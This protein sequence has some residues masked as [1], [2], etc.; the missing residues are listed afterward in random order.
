MFHAVGRPFIRHYNAK[1][2]LANPWG[3]E[4]EEQS[5]AYLHY[6]M[7]VQSYNTYHAKFTRSFPQQLQHDIADRITMNVA[8][9]NVI[10]DNT[11]QWPDDIN[12]L[13][14]LTPVNPPA[15]GYQHLELHDRA[16]IHQ[17]PSSAVDFRALSLHSVSR[18]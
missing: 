11:I 12:I 3:Q 14:H 2:G 8:T 17:V 13:E 9:P 5:Q 6:L 10:L 4:W 18:C 7:V 16:Q 1:Y 15:G